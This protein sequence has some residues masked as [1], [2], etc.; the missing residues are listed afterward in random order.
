MDAALQLK[1]QHS[2][3]N[4]AAPYYDTL[5]QEQLKPAQEL[6]LS[7]AAI[8]NGEWVLD[9]ACGSGLV[10][11]P[12]AL[13]VAPNGKVTATDLSEYMLEIARD[14]AKE[15]GLHH[16]S[17]QQMEAEKL[18]FPDACFDV[19][20]CSL[21][22][23]YVSDPLQVI[24]EMYRVLKPGGRAVAL[25]WGSRE[26]CGWAEIFPIVDKRVTTDVCPL[27]FQQGTGH[28]L[29]YAFDKAGFCDTEEKR[30]ST[31]IHYDNAEDACDA[32]FIGGPVALAWKYFDKQTKVG[33]KEE[34]L[35]S[36]KT[37]KNGKGYDVPAEFVVVRGRKELV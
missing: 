30:F 15:Y 34:Y 27:F 17:F 33:A 10:T 22:L 8:R 35:Y 5:W 37:Y 26:R 20:L 2:G 14:L 24:R 36:L 1:I 32:M 3:W 31:F 7:M 4:K 6:L 16:V 18:T 11:F 9:I 13:A 21:G 28:A 12:A 19:V 29:L 23:M 25:V